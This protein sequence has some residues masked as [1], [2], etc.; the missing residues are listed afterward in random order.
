[1][2]YTTQGP[3]RGGCGHEHETI[4]DAAAC[5]LADQADCERT[6][7]YSDRAV[8]RLDGERLTC[9]ER[10]ELGAA[11]ARMLLGT[12]TA[13]AEGSPRG[14]CELDRKTWLADLI[15]EAVE[16]SQE[17]PPDRWSYVVGFIGARAGF[18]ETEWQA[19]VDMIA[20]PLTVAGPHPESDD[21]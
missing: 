12:G 20:E 15:R 11:V 19:L 21:S 16:K 13:A 5:T 3:V 10:D 1:M 2:T 17:T 6:R 18:S 4:D 9:G 8:C 7:G 14:A